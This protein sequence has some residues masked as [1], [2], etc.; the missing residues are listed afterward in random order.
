MPRAQNAHAIINAGFLFKFNQTSQLIEKATIVYGGI[1]KTFIHA[2]KT[3]AI[4][5]GKNPYTNETLQLALKS[6]KE[7][8]EPEENSPEPS[9]E[10]R[11]MLSICLYYKV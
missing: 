10:Y 11:K 1:S 5:I 2:E 8:I 6:L 9:V 7:E 3:E 4:L